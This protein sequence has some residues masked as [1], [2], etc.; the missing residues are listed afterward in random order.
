MF[1]IF[2]LTLAPLMVVALAGCGEEIQKAAEQ[3]SELAKPPAELK[4]DDI[5]KGDVKLIAEAEGGV[6]DFVVESNGIDVNNESSTDI[7]LDTAS[8]AA[9]IWELI[10]FGFEA[11]DLAYE[12]G[13]C[14]VEEGTS[15]ITF[16]ELQIDGIA[17]YIEAELAGDPDYDDGIEDTY[18]EYLITGSLWFGFEGDD[19]DFIVIGLDNII[20]EG[21]YDYTGYELEELSM[22]VLI[23]AEIDGELIEGWVQI[24][25]FNS[26]FYDL[27][28]NDTSGTLSMTDS[29]NNTFY[30]RTS[31]DDNN[32]V[33]LNN[34]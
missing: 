15:E 1:K 2:K 22:D 29:E 11:L 19:D 27:E 28:G 6:K 32:W 33:E 3:I 30:Y 25:T 14:A 34:L 23:I 7:V 4:P 5:K 20:D 12:D 8:D 26:F 24:D 21:S 16:C 31:I 17:I 10:E 18:D 13:N 9:E